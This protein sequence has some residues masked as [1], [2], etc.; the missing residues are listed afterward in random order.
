[1]NSHQVSVFNQGAITAIIPALAACY[2]EGIIDTGL[3]LTHADR[4]VRACFNTFTATF[5]K[6]FNKTHLWPP[7][8]TFGIGAPFAGQG[9][10]FEKNNS[11]DTRSVMNRITLYVGNNSTIH[12]RK[13]RN[14]ENVIKSNL[15]V[16]FISVGTVIWIVNNLFCSISDHADNQGARRMA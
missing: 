4:V 9:A 15:L 13:R 10:A 5:T 11:P 16:S 2:T 7:G 8:D 1:M 3:I 6:D 14:F 12:F